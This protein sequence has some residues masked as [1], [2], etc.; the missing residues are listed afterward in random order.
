MQTQHPLAVITPTLDGDVLAVLA[1]ADAPHTVGGVQKL[2]GGRSHEGIR[3]V[4]TRLTA[5]GTVTAQQVS[6]VVS[7]RLN[8]EHL[9]AEHIIAL[10]DLRGAL[11]DRVRTHVQAWPTPPVWAALFGSAARGQMLPDSDVDLFLVDPAIDADLWEAL[12]DQ[13]SREV[14]RWTGNDARVLSMTEAEVRMSAATR[15]PIVQSLL[16]DALTISGEPTWLRRAV[17][18]A[19]R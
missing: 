3:K 19:R 6:A 14:S 17:A 13:L 12:V 7:Y 1:A 2:L 16:E 9:A 4:L 5:Q 18:R 10:A 8:R 15:D 11:M